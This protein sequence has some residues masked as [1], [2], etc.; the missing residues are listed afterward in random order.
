[1]LNFGLDH[2]FERPV[3]DLVFDGSDVYRLLC[4]NQ[5]DVQ[6]EPKVS[7]KSIAILHYESRS[8]TRRR[9]SGNV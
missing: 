9:L 4:L 1:M 3:K 6:S 5:P 7:P 2:P 8:P